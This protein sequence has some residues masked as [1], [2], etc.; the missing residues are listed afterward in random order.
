MATLY[1]STDFCSVGA[2]NLFSIGSLVLG[3]KLKKKVLLRYLG[4]WTAD[5]SLPLSP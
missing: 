2:I 4:S 5:I 3:L 1:I